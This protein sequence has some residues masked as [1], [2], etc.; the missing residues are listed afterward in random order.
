MMK[1]GK[2]FVV[3][4]F[5]FALVFAFASDSEAAG[6]KGPSIAAVAESV[7]ASGPYAGQ[8][9]TLL[10]AVG[11]ADPAVGATLTGNGQH[12]VFAPTDGAFAEL[13][14]TP[15]NI[16]D[17]PQEV[18]TQILLYHVANGRRDAAD[19]TT[20]SQIRTL[21]GGFIQVDGTI[22]NGDINIFLPDVFAANGV[23]HV[24]D[25]VLLP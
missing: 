7:N 6:P 8:F 3:L 25:G 18:L 20:S 1:L 14:Y 15:E 21:Q 24:V 9:D 10:A 19:V 5:A 13:G 4:A 12:T 16:V 22:L 2:L 23:I 11:A 17:V